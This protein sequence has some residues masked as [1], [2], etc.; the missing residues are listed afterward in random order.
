MLAPNIS[1][2][3]TAS[4]LQINNAHPLFP[5][6][7]AGTPLLIVINN[8]VQVAHT[9]PYTRTHTPDVATPL[10]RPFLMAHL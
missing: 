1:T 2:Q 4:L 8:A 7:L 6:Q 3:I 5:A 9:L 10:S